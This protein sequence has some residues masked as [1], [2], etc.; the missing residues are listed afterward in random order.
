MGIRTKFNLGMVAVFLLAL[1]IAAWRMDE[2]FSA[3]ARREVLLDASIML[4]AANAVRQYTVDEI[5]P[6]VTGDDPNWIAPITVPSY[7]AQANFRLI[8]RDHPEFLYK[9]AALNPTNPADRALDWE[10]DLI[11]AFRNGPMLTEL[12]HERNT[13]TGPVLTVARPIT[14]RDEACLACHSTPDRAPPRMI[15]V[16]G[17]AN[18]FGWRMGETVGVQLISVPMRHALDRARTNMERFLLGLFGM[19]LGLM[20]TFNLLLH[21]VVI[22]PVTRMARSATAVSLGKSGEAVDFAE[23]RRDEIGEM[24]RAFNRMRRSLEQA[25]KMLGS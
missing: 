7:A 20:V 11:H 21:F 5:V 17:A 23:Q 24:G 15:E 10:A 9:E 2:Q 16:Y 3:S 18:G 12:A 25:V 14:I 8:R 22:R 1:G 19:F 6:L 4:S 13:P